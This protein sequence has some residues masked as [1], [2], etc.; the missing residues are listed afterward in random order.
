MVF[1][2]GSVLGFI[3]WQSKQM[4]FPFVGGRSR[5]FHES[6]CRNLGIT[7]RTHKT[8]SRGKA[9]KALEELIL[10]DIPVNIHVDMVYLKYLNLPPE[11][12]FGAHTVVV[13]GIDEDKAIAYVADTELDILQAVSLKELE[14]ARD[15]KFKPFPPQNRWFTF[16]F[17]Q[18]L[19][20]LP[21]AVVSAID[22]TASNM[23]NSPTRNFG[24]K[25][26]RHFASDIINWP[27]CYPPQEFDWAYEMTYIML[28]EDGTGGGCF[29]YLYSRF[30]EEASEVLGDKHLIPFSKEYYRVGEKWT[31][32]AHLI[33]S[34]PQNGAAQVL[35]IKT[36]L[37]EIAD[38]EEYILKKL[39]GLVK[40]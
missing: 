24:T 14:A 1:G 32:V 9:Y 23:L 40:A 13:A 22:T 12:H 29:R 8:S 21:H 28:E 26:I 6:L 30:L 34:I 11:A 19:T 36:L 20:P 38:E 3:Y 27:R 4:P 2:L 10:R 31:Q 33:R 37:L 35:Q 18:E 17:P 16:E 5:N 7:L 15:S 39:A 25:G